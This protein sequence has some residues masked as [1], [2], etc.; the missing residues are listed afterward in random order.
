MTDDRGV[1]HALSRE[2]ADLLRTSRPRGTLHQTRYPQITLS[3]QTCTSHTPTRHLL[4]V[5]LRP[6]CFIFKL[7]TS[8]FLSWQID[9]FLIAS[10]TRIVTLVR[11]YMGKGNAATERDPETNGRAHPS[12]VAF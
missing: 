7:E 5:S 12:P 6:C 2:R 3:E 1:P 10:F 8:A 4:Y 9:K 11:G